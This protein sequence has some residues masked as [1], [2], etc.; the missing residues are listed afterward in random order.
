MAGKIQNEDVKSS[1]EIIAAGG[2]DSQLINDT[3]I[4]VASLSKRLDQAI[5]AGD[6]GGASLTVNSPAG[7]VASVT[8]GYM[9][10][11]DSSAARTIQL[12]AATSGMFFY[13]KDKTGTMS[14][15]N[16]TIVRAAAESVE[17]V[18]SNYTL[19]ADW[20]EWLFFSDGTNWFVA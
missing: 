11:I 10:L 8:K 4:Y 17:G 20:G 13:V 1:T 3:K 14:S 19:E 7:N 12:P 9:Y 15:F 6:I 5:A 2:A 16:C 18:A